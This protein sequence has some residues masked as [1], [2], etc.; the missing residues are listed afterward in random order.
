MNFELIYE[1][2][3]SYFPEIIDISDGSEMDEGAAF[4]SN[5]LSEA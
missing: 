3:L 1:Q 2:V 4:K 5:N